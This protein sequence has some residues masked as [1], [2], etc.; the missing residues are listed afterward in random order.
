MHD[1][2]MHLTED[3]ITALTEVGLIP[4][5]FEVRSIFEATDQG[6]RADRILLSEHRLA[7]PYI[8]EYD[9]IK[10]NGP[11]T[12]AKRFD[13]SHW[14]LLGAQAEG[15]RVGAAVVAFDTPGLDMLEGRADLAVLWDIRVLPEFRGQGVGSALFRSAEGWAGRRSCRQLRVETQNINVPACRFYARQ[16]CGLERM[17]RSAYPDFP[18]EIQLLWGKD[19][20]VVA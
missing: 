8:K 4:G 16:G 14:G 13:V 1:M 15:R 7:V 5:A 6:D 9:S 3:P 10:G 20:V 2:K 17:N 19:V 18:D 11:A 12:W